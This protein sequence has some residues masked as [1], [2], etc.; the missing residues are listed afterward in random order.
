LTPEAAIFGFPDHR[1]S[2]IAMDT[3]GTSHRPPQLPKTSESPSPSPIRVVVPFLESN[4]LILSKLMVSS[5]PNRRS[6]QPLHTA[7]IFNGP[8]S[9]P[10][11]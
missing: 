11:G 4:T 7:L 6:V 8:V 1:V 5:L 3:E 9:L 2:L 10:M